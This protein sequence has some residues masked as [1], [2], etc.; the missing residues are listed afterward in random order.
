MIEAT[1]ME[2]YL[3]EKAKQECAVI[4]YV[5]FGTL[6]TLENLLVN[7][8]RERDELKMRLAALEAGGMVLVPKEPTPE[9]VREHNR[10]RFMENGDVFRLWHA[11]LAARP[12]GGTND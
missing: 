12:Q 5:T 6:Q 8:Q 1:E 2:N 4:G 9:M 10:V 3:I 11:M 7:A